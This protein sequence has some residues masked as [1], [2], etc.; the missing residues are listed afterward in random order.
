M[1]YTIK[2]LLDGLEEKVKLRTEEL[3]KAKEKAEVANHAK[4][5]FLAKYES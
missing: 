5:E 2:I 3:V 1:A 4:S